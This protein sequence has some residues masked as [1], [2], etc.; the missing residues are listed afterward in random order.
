MMY[1]H[2]HIFQRME[3]SGARNA[4]LKGVNVVK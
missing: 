3:R 2:Q 1:L 4:R